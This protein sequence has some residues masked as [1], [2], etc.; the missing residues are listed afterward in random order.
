M[1][2]DIILREAEYLQLG[3]PLRYEL[4]TSEH[5]ASGYYEVKNI[6]RLYGAM[7]FL[8]FDS[9]AHTHYGTAR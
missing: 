4:T 7:Q 6:K 8:F 9:S 2:S 5:K 3:K 1:L